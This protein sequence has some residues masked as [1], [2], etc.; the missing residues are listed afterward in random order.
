MLAH[1]ATCEAAEYR[2][3]QR[4]RKKSAKQCF[5]LLFLFRGRVCRVDF[6]SQILQG[7]DDILGVIVPDLYLTTM[8]MKGRSRSLRFTCPGL[9]KLQLIMR[10]KGGPFGEEGGL[11]NMASFVSSTWESAQYHVTFLDVRL[12]VF[13][14]NGVATKNAFVWAND[15]TVGF[16]DEDVFSWEGIESHGVSE[17]GYEGITQGLYL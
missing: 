2:S 10:L 13:H 11:G 5:G 9:P 8:D 17:V 3:Y 4:M 16:F 7:V 15:S 1:N 6:T 12:R 14:D